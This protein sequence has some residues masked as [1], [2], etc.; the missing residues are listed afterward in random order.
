METLHELKE[1]GSIVGAFALFGTLF[2]IILFQAAIVVGIKLASDGKTE[3]LPD[4]TEKDSEMILYP[5]RKWLEKKKVKQIIYM[6][7]QLVNLVVAIE[8]RFAPIDLKPDHLYKHWISFDSKEKEE[9][10]RQMIGKIQQAFQ[11]RIGDTVDG[12]VFYIEEEY[13]IRSK[14]VRLPILGCVT[15]MPSFW[16]LFLYWV[17][18]VC[19]FG[20]WIMEIPLWIADICT[21]SAIAT[22]LYKAIKKNEY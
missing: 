4:G 10:F 3:I 8:Q 6:D 2:L 13:F 14:W 9:I 7:D 15:C 16:S 1:W 5:I 19:L 12:Y 22:W 17:P 11:L 18:V 21:V 20:F